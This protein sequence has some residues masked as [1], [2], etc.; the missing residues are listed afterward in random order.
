MT[1]LL[2]GTIR[3]GWG[4]AVIGASKLGASW[5][6]ARWQGPEVQGGLGLAFAGMSFGAI[7]LSLGLDYANAFVVGRRPSALSAVV[8]N[9]ALISLAAAVVGIFWCWAFVAIFPKTFPPGVG[10]SALLI[11]ALGLGTGATVATQSLQ[12]ATIGAQ[13]LSGVALANILNGGIWLLIAVPLARI[14]DFRSLLVAWVL[15]LG[16]VAGFQSTRLLRARA[17]RE[18]SLATLKDQVGFGVRTLPGGVAR[19]LNMRAALYLGSVALGPADLGVF[20][21]YLNVAEAMLYLPN[22]LSQVILARTARAG[23][24]APPIRAAYGF[25]AAVGA[26]AVIF[27]LVWGSGLL[28][29]LIGPAYGAHAT[30]LAV[31]LLGTT[32]HAVGLI[33]IHVLM[34][35]GRPGAASVAQLV[36][37]GFTVVGVGVLV[38]RL[39]LDGAALS[40]LIAY[41]AF[42]GY[43]FVVRTEAR[44]DTVPAT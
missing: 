31:L 14:G 19:A 9:T 13:D 27:T 17:G 34:G 29:A 6:I 15:V 44:R 38:P 22:A 23:H 12:S 42:A 4:L 7:V 36:T 1:D 35:M 30:A 26:A 40:M 32:A 28:T 41:G 10:T 16:I 5:A 18:P 39:G 33:R 24:N 37:L 11:G 2:R 25:V 20:V 3:T 21:L 43:L 8:R